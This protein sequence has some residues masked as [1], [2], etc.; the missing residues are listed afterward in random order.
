MFDEN[1]KARDPAASG[2]SPCA[3]LSFVGAPMVHLRL[4]TAY[5]MKPAKRTAL[6]SNAL[7]KPP[8][9]KK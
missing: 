1:Y 8:E 5:W 9:K 3:A 7:V 2:E 6:A 4:E